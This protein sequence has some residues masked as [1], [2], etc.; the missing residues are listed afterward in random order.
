MNKRNCC[1]YVN[2]GGCAGIQGWIKR[3]HTRVK[4][5]ETEDVCSVVLPKLES[6]QT[7]LETQHAM[8]PVNNMIMAQEALLPII[9]TQKYTQSPQKGTQFFMRSSMEKAII[10]PFLKKQ[11]KAKQS[12]NQMSVSGEWSV[13][14]G[15][16]HGE[17]QQLCCNTHKWLSD[18][19]HKSSMGQESSL[20]GPTSPVFPSQMPS[21]F[22]LKMPDEGSF[23]KNNRNAVGFC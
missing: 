2:R 8:T 18:L 14:M 11:N 12:D 7:S 15:L 10:K 22:N 4:R 6:Q 17:N 1:C 21:K 16:Q 3:K 13:V 5:N 20:N 9:I 19:N 23:V